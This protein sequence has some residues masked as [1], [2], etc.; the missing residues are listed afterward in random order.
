[1]SDKVKLAMMTVTVVM[2]VVFAP[3]LIIISINVLFGATIPLT[4]QTWLATLVLV[5]SLRWA[6]HPKITKGE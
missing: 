1:M 6:V 5:N 3:L 4:W 2:F